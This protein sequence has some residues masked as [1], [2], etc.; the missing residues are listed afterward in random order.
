MTHFTGTVTIA[1]G[2]D[3]SKTFDCGVSLMADSALDA[4]LVACQLAYIPHPGKPDHLQIVDVA[5][6]PA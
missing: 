1:D 4:S 2:D 3:F 6:S 5:I